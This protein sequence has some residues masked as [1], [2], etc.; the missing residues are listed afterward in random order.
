[1]LTGNDETA[2]RFS[3]EKKKKHNLPESPLLD[4]LK[5]IVVSISGLNSKLEVDDYISN[6]L[7]AKHAK[8]IREEY[9]RVVPNLD[10][11]YDFEC[12]SCGTFSRIGIP[13]T[14]E[15]FWPQR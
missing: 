13:F 12:D 7:L 1:M 15:F 5:A 3:S 10:L 6:R 9:A 8:F 2:L 14:A 11:K 4:Q